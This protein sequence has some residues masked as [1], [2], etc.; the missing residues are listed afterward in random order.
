MHSLREVLK[1]Y[2]DA[3]RAPSALAGSIEGGV[4]TEAVLPSKIIDREAFRND[5]AALKRDNDRYFKICVM[6]IVLLFV[7][8]VGVVLGNL[9]RPDWIKIALT[10]FGVSSAGLITVMINLWRTKSNTEVLLI[11]VPN[12]D[13]DTLKTVI[14]ILAKRL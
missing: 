5:L 3:V 7:V 4:A 11:L 1:D 10:G 14:G 6:M 8:S 12:V 2:S 9:S 13:S